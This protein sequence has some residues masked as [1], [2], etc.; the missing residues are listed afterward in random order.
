MTYGYISGLIKEYSSTHYTKNSKSVVVQLLF[1][2]H[3]GARDSEN[4]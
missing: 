4:I 1:N 3:F 2:G